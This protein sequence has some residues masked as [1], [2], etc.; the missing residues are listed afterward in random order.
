MALERISDATVYDNERGIIQTHE[1]ALLSNG[2]VKSIAGHNSKENAALVEVLGK[3]NLSIYNSVHRLSLEN[4]SDIK[5]HLSDLVLT[6]QWRHH[7]LGREVAVR[8]VELAMHSP[9]TANLTEK[10]QK[11]SADTPYDKPTRLGR[12]LNGKHIEKAAERAL[13]DGWSLGDRITEERLLAEETMIIQAHTAVLKLNATGMHVARKRGFGQKKERQSATRFSEQKNEESNTLRYYD[14]SLVSALADIEITHPGALPSEYREILG[15]L[16][17]IISFIK[18]QRDKPVQYH[19]FTDEPGGYSYIPSNLDIYEYKKPSAADTPKDSTSAVSA[20]DKEARRES[21][22]QQVREREER[23]AEQLLKQEEERQEIERYNTPIL[24]ELSRIKS[25]HD[26]LLDE[27]VNQPRK[28]LREIGIFGQDS[29]NYILSQQKNSDQITSER[30]ARVYAKLAEIANNENPE[31]LLT[32]YLTRIEY[33]AAE[34]RVYLHEHPLRGG[35]TLTLDKFR[36]GI[37]GEIDWLTSNWGE[38]CRAIE[39]SSHYR[40]TSKSNLQTVAELLGINQDKISPTGLTVDSTTPKGTF[41]DTPNN[42]NTETP[43]TQANRLAE[44]LN[45]VVLPDESITPD[46][47]VDIAIKAI[48]DTSKGKDGDIAATVER[49][50]MEGL[51]KLR[52]EYGGLLYR[53]EEKTLGDSDNLYFVHR[54][55]HPG[56]GNWYAVAE[57]P[58]YGNATYVLREDTLPLMP[59]ETTLTAVKQGRQTVRGLGAQRIIH[60]TPQ[61]DTH[62]EKIDKCIVE[63]SE[64]ETLS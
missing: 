1:S 64:Q 44:Q 15:P 35:A 50:R 27:F 59:G 7:V 31:E 43:L 22:E 62:L 4:S 8:S 26:R 5:D 49:Y 37:R 19:L 12:K 11:L 63:L 34:Y 51:L 10:L 32:D 14:R 6:D 55:Q 56:D 3:K 60:G 9:L 48:K 16:R 24:A 2:E 33:L 29:L 25:E 41:S 18:E 38:F 21:I 57:N 42:S 54:F 23:K 45:W 28:H 40:S 39:S 17:S 13:S 47:L 61:L 36:E 46:Q 58:V 30:A 20:V 52:E 53:S